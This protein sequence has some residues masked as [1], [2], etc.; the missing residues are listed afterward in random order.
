MK[1][2]VLLTTLSAE[3]ESSQLKEMYD[4]MLEALYNPNATKF[5]RNF[6]AAAAAEMQDGILLNA[7]YACIRCAR[8]LCR[9]HKQ[10]MKEHQ[11]DTR[12]YFSS[13]SIEDNTLS[14]DEGNDNSD[15]D[16]LLSQVQAPT[17][18]VPK[19]ALVNGHFR[20]SVPLCIARLTRVE[21][22]MI[23]RINCIYNLSM[24]K[25]GCHWGSTATVFS[26]LNDVHQIAAILPR[27]PSI[28]DWAIIRSAV[29]VA[30]PRQYNYTPYNVV[31]ALEWLQENN[32]FWENC[33]QLP[34]GLPEWDK[35]NEV[36]FM[37]RISAPVIDASD[38]DYE[39]LNDDMNGVSGEDGHVV[40]P[41]APP[42]NIADVFLQ[43]SDDH[44]DIMSQVQR[45]IAPNAQ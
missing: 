3:I 20:G 33:M 44:Q 34:K 32:P 38:E 1:D 14:D 31:A 22:S 2:C 12:L 40:N 35:K 15:D 13:S 42:S 8:Q 19:M 37:S 43:Y 25:R 9:F 5:E 4:T 17:K 16:E 23:C 21:L 36:A 7:V 18:R 6:A 29:D 11:P 26:V 10:F 28:N 41:N 39:G 30:S 27:M 24:L 45:I